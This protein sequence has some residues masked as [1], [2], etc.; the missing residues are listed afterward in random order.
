MYSNSILYTL[1]KINQLE[2]YLYFL[3]TDFPLQGNL[4][5][6]QH[7]ITVKKIYFEVET[8]AVFWMRPENSTVFLPKLSF[9]EAMLLWVMLPSSRLG[10]QGMVHVRLV[11]LS[12][13]SL[14]TAQW[15]MQ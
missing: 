11:L 13:T 2:I 7:Y 10:D 14:T 1:K 5:P 6:A 3:C 12:S 15:E 4:S 8:V 9:S